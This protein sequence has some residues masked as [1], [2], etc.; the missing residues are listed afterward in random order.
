MKIGKKVF[1]WGE[2][3]YIMG[4][5][6]V[7]PDSFSDG[8]RYLDPE[9]AVERALEMQAQ[10]A[11]II[12]VGGESTRPGSERVGADEELKRVEPVL[13]EICDKLSVPVSID[14]YKSEVAEAA[15]RAGAAMINDISALRFDSGM[16]N[17]V[18]EYDVPVVLM[19]MKGTPKGMQENPHYD[20][21]MH[22]IISFLHERKEFAV[23]NGIDGEKI[24]V[25]PGIGFGKR[26]GK[27]I[28]DNCEI[29]GRLRELK[30]LGSPILVGPS[31]KTFIGNVC[32]DDDKPL[33]V[34]RRIEGTL[35]AVA[36]SAVNGA[37]IVRV[38]DV[39]E[40]RRCLKLVD[41][42][43]RKTQI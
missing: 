33:P 19:H 35:A 38:H 7:T 18:K 36:L 1:R 11:D 22:E 17:V 15:I 43:I 40:A 3:T 21:V 6:N 20:D 10:G 26:T 27:G 9:R 32:S 13:E 2:R 31:R 41:S 16:V 39:A 25:D 29:I 5:L 34:D 12:D 30:V 37:D 24:I 4:V 42:I 28:E 23:N 14:T 8:G